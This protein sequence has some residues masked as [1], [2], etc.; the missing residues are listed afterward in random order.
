MK[1]KKA[2][3]IVISAFILL[4]LSTSVFASNNQV[5]IFNE[6]W[7]KQSLDLNNYNVNIYKNVV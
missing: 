5:G 4:T 7:T 1:L 6:I 2:T 3:V